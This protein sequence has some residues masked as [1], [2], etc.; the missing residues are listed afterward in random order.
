MDENGKIIYPSGHTVAHLYL[1]ANLMTHNLYSCPLPKS[2][3]LKVSLGRYDLKGINF[4]RLIF[5]FPLSLSLL[6]LG[7][8]FDLEAQAASRTV[9]WMDIGS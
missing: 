8:K 1:A 7:K 3:V 9:R 2:S 4:Q 6:L 5:I